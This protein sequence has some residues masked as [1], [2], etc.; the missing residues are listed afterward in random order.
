MKNKLK[1]FLTGQVKA[2]SDEIFS[3]IA[4]SGREDRD[5]D[6]INPNG[7]DLTAYKNNPIL[8]WG[9]NPYNPPVGKALNLRVEG[10]QL[11]FDFSMANTPMGQELKTLIKDGYLN[12]FSVGFIP[13]EFGDVNAGGYTFQKCELLEISLVSI[14]S[15]VDAMVTSRSFQG[16]SA[17]T[18]QFV[19]AE[20][21]RA[22]TI[23]DH[24][25]TAFPE[26]K[27][28]SWDEEAERRGADLDSLKAMATYIDDEAPSDK[29]SYKLLHHASGK[30]YPL[31]KAGL[32][33]AV[34]RLSELPEEV[35]EGAYAH[36]KDHYEELGLEAPKYVAAAKDVKPDPTKSAEQVV[37]VELDEA[38]RQL[39]KRVADNLEKASSPIVQSP[40]A[41]KKVDRSRSDVDTKAYAKEVMIR[42]LQIIAKSTSKRLHELKK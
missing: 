38:D 1:Q 17:Q 5:G 3:G 10:G 24:G 7:W 13:R 32:D 12:T 22:K 39:L 40:E 37:T 2:L 25:S 18:K 4:S 29:A 33:D 15:N 34:Q 23:V 20:I 42:A 27:E 36:L 6:T 21:K 16:M 28:Y 41:N 26:A 11:R 31:V 8:L 30:E 14:P 9:H 35:R 19:L